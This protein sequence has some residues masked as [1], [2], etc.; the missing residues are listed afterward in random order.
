MDQNGELLK[1][2]VGDWV[3]VRDDILKMADSEFKKFILQNN[4][5]TALK[6]VKVEH[7]FTNQSIIFY[8]LQ[9][10]DIIEQNIEKFFRFATTKEIKKQ[11]I[12]SIFIK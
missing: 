1:L 12:K 7:S 6:I 9:P 11:Q 2:S 10:F 4:Y 5:H 8:H 3:I